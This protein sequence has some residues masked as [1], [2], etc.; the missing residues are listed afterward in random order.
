M[1]L[2][3]F[4]LIYL[5]G[6]RRCQGNSCDANKNTPASS[7]IKV[8]LWSPNIHYKMTNFDL[9][10]SVPGFLDWT[11]NWLDKIEID[12]NFFLHRKLLFL[13]WWRFRGSLANLRS[14]DDW[15]E[16]FDFP[17]DLCD[18]VHDIHPSS[19]QL[20]PLFFATSS[21]IAIGSFQQLLPWIIKIPSFPII[22]FMVKRDEAVNVPCLSFSNHVSVY[23][24]YVQHLL[25]HP[26][27]SFFK[28]R[29]DVYSVEAE[30]SSVSIFLPHFFWFFS[31]ISPSG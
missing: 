7:L 19:H 8:E 28:L 25:F 4:T 3:S 23:I 17:L 11:F 20:F 6:Q 22:S 10:P 27:P 1:I 31:S 21:V 30:R 26:F 12:A 16:L 29:W 9:D 5:H 2:Y 13:K 14:V 24:V 18:I 15:V